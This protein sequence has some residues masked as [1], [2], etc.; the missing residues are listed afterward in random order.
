MNSQNWQPSFLLPRDSGGQYQ[1]DIR[2]VYA[3]SVHIASVQW[4]AYEPVFKEWCRGRLL[5]AG[6]GR[7]P[8]YGFLRDRVTSYYAV[9]YSQ[10]AAVESLLDETC[11]LNTDFVLREKAF[12]TVLLSDVIAHVRYPDRLI[13]NLTAHMA[14][15]GALVLT[16]PCVYW[17]SEYPH[18]YYHM[19][20]FALRDICESAGL[21]LELCSPYGGYPDVLLDTCNKG[22]TGPITNRLFRMLASVVKKT[23]WYKRTNEKTKYSYPIGYVLVARKRV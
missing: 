18:E 15:G 17:M 11:D 13:K 19:T 5:D 4:K 7:A 14:P 16:T 3:G 6:C 8:Y 20:E 21:T 9:D 23:G 1:V 22:M 10:N 12:D 2:R